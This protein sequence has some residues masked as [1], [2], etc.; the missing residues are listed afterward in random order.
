MLCFDTV[1]QHKPSFKGAF[2]LCDE[3][4]MGITRRHDESKI[5][6]TSAMDWALR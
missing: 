3:L 5:F 6:L 1:I 2:R 4:L